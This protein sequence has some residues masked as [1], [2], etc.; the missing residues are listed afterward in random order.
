[1]SQGSTC[2]VSP[3][4]SFARREACAESE[5]PFV[6]ACSSGI[7]GVGHWLKSTAHVSFDP[8]C[9]GSECHEAFLGNF[10]RLGAF[11]GHCIVIHVTS[12]FNDVRDLT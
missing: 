11:A 1:M 4:G 10:D 9:N 2:G 8:D 6:Y 5:V 3:A 12:G 7:N